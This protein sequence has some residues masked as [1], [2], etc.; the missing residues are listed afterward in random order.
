ME[1][2]IRVVP[3]LGMNQGGRT[4]VASLLLPLGISFFTFQIVGYTVDV[5]RNPRVVSKSLLDPSVFV[6]LFAHLIAGPIM[7]ATD[8]LP[9]VARPRLPDDEEIH[10]GHYLVRGLVKKVVLGDFFGA[11]VDSVYASARDHSWIF[12]WL[13][14]AVYAF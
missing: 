10:E 4:Y 7:R 13:A 1:N 8:L 14:A 11:I 5:Y 12:L 2:L 6:M 3:S 9:Q